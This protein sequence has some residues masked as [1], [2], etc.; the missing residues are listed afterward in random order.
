LLLNTIDILESEAKSNYITFYNRC[1]MNSFS[2][3]V[4]T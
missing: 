3:Q 4:Q 1:L 2:Y